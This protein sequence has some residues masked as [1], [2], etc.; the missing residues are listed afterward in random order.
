MFETQSDL[1]HEILELMKPVDEAEEAKP[2][3][4]DNYNS[5]LY[6]FYEELKQIL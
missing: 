3:I 1:R 6:R 5:A 2:F 4:W